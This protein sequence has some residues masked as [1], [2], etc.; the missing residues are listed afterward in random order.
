[1]SLFPADAASINGVQSPLL[2]RSSTLA[3][4][5]NKTWASS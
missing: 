3:L 4:M 5:A 1:M 2:P